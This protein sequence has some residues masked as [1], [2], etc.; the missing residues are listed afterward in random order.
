MIQLLG[1]L[2]LGRMLRLSKII[3]YLNV[4]EDVKA[5]MKLSKLI[6]FLILYMHFSSCFFWLLIDYERDWLPQAVQLEEA[7]DQELY[8]MFYNTLPISS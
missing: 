1:I 6:F 3:S 2:K 5:S 8:D 7:P 4:D